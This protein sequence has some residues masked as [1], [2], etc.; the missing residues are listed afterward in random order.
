MKLLLLILFTFLPMFAR[1]DYHSFHEQDKFVHQTYFSQVHS[2]VFV[3]IGAY[4]GTTDSHTKFFE[5]NLGWTGLCVEPMPKAFSSLE[6]NRSCWCVQ[7]C[8]AN[9]KGNGQFLN[10]SS[11]HANIEMLSGLVD[12][13][14]P[15]H[16]NRIMK[17]IRR[18]EGACELIDVN[19]YMINDLLSENEINHI[20]FLSL[21]TVGSEM[22]ILS[23]FDFNRLK[24]D[25]IMVED[26]HQDKRISL[27][28]TSKGYELDKRIQNSAIFVHQDFMY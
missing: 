13:Y 5:S 24:I 2:G 8:I 26:P 10:I 3:D 21:E 19:C 7:G 1:A 9:R 27:F 25:V 11:P 12:R 4:D 6:N 14:E 20:N 16:L 18:F 28:L 23:T 15:K 17:E 22:E